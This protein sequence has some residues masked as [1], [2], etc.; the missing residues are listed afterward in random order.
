MKFIKF[1]TLTSSISKDN[2]NSKKEI[3]FAWNEEGYRKI[4]CSVSKVPI[5]QGK[6][7][8]PNNIIANFSRSRMEAG[9]NF[10]GLHNKFSNDSAK[11]DSI[12]VMVDKLS[13]ETH[14]FQ[15]SPLT[16]QVK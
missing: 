2:N 4:H 5:S 16:K 8:T 11:H 15:S 10:Y 3:L 14:S 7:S 12:V 6:A 13:K 9:D 1:R